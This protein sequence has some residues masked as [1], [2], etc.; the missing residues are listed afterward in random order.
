MAKKTSKKTTRSAPNPAGPPS[1]DQRIENL[2]AEL[3]AA[4]VKQAESLAESDPEVAKLA[5]LLV[6]Q[7]KKTTLSKFDRS[8]IKSLGVTE[9]EYLAAKRNR[10][11]EE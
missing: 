9:A 7:Q 3:S 5:G 1:T 6:S 8:M 10:Q 11:S 4:K 2:K